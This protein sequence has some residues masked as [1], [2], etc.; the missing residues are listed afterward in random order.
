[1][2]PV[3]LCRSALYMPASNARAIAKA[4]T[5]PADCVIL[6][7]EDAVAPEMK[8]TARRAAAEAVRAGG[9]GR[10]GVVI[11]VNDLSTLWAAADLAAAG[12]AAPDAVL[13]PKVEG[14][15]DIARATQALNETGAPEKTRLWVMIETPRAVLGVAAIA[16]AGG[17]LAGFVLGTNDLAAALRLPG[18]ARAR[19][20]LGPSLQLALLAARAEGLLILDGVYNDIADEAG[21]AAECTEGRAQGFDG[22]TLIHPAQIEPANRAFSPDP[23]AVAEA[24]AI[25]AAFAAPEAQGKG[26]IQHKGRMV[27]R[28][29][30]AEAERLIAMAEAIAAA[31]E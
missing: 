29:H 22:K 23:A 9:F 16:A 14:P 13:L 10:R 26:A 6:D 12:A 25:M 31:P 4:R 15:F 3:K 17:R 28:L 21:F 30:L 11:R 20:Q 1:M 8:E 7:L 27:E 18:G 5:L 24:R 2:H 19:R